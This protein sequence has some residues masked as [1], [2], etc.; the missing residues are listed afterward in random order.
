MNFPYAKYKKMLFTVPLIILCSAAIPLIPLILVY[1]RIIAFEDGFLNM[2]LTLA[3]CLIIMACICL[4]LPQ[5]LIYGIM[6]AIEK[7]E[8]A[9]KEE[10][11]VTSIRVYGFAGGVYDGKKGPYLIININDTSYCI[12]AIG[13]IEEVDYVQFTY[14]PKSNV[15]LSMKKSDSL[16]S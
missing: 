16:T 7:P 6:L 9:L 10:G 13:R 11:T 2:S 15:I 4:S 1:K 3:L 8:S 5:L 14:L 12:M